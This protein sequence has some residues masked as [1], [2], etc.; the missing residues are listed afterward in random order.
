MSGWPAQFLSRALICHQGA[1]DQRH[2]R[3]DVLPEIGQRLGGICQDARVV[4]G[5]FQ[6]SPGEIGALQTVHLRI[7][8]PTVTDQPITAECGPGEC[9]PL[10]RI[11]R[12]RLLHRTQRLR[13]LS[14]R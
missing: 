3:A 1:V 7:F 12:D 4:A 14:C 10:T 5:H 11:A 2:H 6:G 9:G 13:D 8:A